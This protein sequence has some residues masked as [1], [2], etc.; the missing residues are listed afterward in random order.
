M[1]FG[2]RIEITATL[3]VCHDLHVGTASKQTLRDAKGEMREYAQTVRDHAENPIVP[4]SSLKG[5]IR[6]RLT[7]EDADWLSDV[8][9]EA[10]NVETATGKVGKLWIEPL[11]FQDAGEQLDQMGEQPSVNGVYHAKHVSIDRSRGSAADNKLFDREM[12]GA[13]SQFEFKAI[14][15]GEAEE[16]EV[17]V[18]V[19]A[20]LD[21]GIQIGAGASKGYGQSELDQN[22]IRLTEY[23][24][25]E[26]GI[27]RG[28]ELRPEGL[29]EAVKNYSG[30]TRNAKAVTKLRLVCQ[31]PFLSVRK[32]EGNA[33]RPIERKDKPVIQPDSFIGALR[34]VA[35]K[36][37]RLDGLDARDDPDANRSTQELKA[38]TGLSDL[39][40]LFGV[41]GRKSALFVQKIECALPGDRVT[42]ASNSIDRLTGAGRD[43]A[44]FEREA[45]WKPE[46]TVS[47]HTDGEHALFDRLI[48][49]LVKE[50][51]VLEIGHGASVG[52]G[53]FDV[54]VVT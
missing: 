44:L 6:S 39:E 37:Q 42:I 4:G 53:W 31:G 22:T 14:W 10:S 3:T 7:D 2:S 15:F 50:N 29:I 45:F 23:R 52:F 18:P 24:P 30:N 33:L 12:V 8:F 54:E 5:V 11:C 34:S 35:Q 25:D 51:T 13:G 36:L 46:F 27:L 20:V 48:G 21:D 26:H 47:L 1:I 41:S 38:V 40:T 32:N 43:G 19:L 9:G 28:S 49:H 16:L 17:V